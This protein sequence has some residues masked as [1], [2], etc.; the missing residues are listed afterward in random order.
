MA[1]EFPE[2]LPQSTLFVKT[3]PRN[4]TTPILPPAPDNLDRATLE[5]LFSLLA[6]IWSSLKTAFTEQYI[7]LATRQ[8]VLAE[9]EAL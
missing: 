7:I 4:C 1:G 6:T 8:K 3:N 9:W 2:E 5:A